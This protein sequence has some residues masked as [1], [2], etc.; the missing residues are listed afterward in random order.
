[1]LPN[2]TKVVNDIKKYL[3]YYATQLNNE[4]L[5]LKDVI[6]N[7]NNN[8]FQKFKNKSKQIWNEFSVFLGLINSKNDIN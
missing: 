3:I 2:D 8:N 1:M 6:E 7:I 4:Y 5:R